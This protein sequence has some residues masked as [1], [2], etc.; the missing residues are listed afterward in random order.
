MIRV[1]TFQTGDC[2]K[3]LVEALRA[4]S[5]VDIHDVILEGTL[6]TRRPYHQTFVAEDTETGLIIGTASLLIERKPT[7][8]G[9][10]VGHIEDVA[11]VGPWQGMGVGALLVAAC[12]AEAVNH[13]CRKIVLECSE[14]KVGFYEREGFRRSGVAMRLDL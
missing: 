4:L 5:P 8:K 3:G 1:R 10:E 7:H 13:R 2:E 6:R 14:E 11:V 12:K 9:Q